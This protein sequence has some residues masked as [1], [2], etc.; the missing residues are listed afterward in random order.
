MRR[1]NPETPLGLRLFLTLY[2]W[3]GGY[4]ERYFRPLF[5]AGVLFV[6]STIG[7][8]GCGLT[9][10]HGGAPLAWGN[11]RDWLKAADYSIRV[12]TLLKPDDWTP[13]A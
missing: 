9:P 12:M 10:K 5:W 11:V 6:S 8:M 2:R 1:Q 13:Q 4:G 3:F 7:Y